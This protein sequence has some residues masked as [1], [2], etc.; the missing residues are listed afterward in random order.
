MTPITVNSEPSAF[1]R[2][3]L[4]PMTKVLNPL[5]RRLAGRKHF[6]Q[7]ARLTHLGRRSGRA[8]VTPVSARPGGGHFWVALT[9]GTGSDWCRNVVAAGGC[10][11]R[12]HGRD[13][14]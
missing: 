11:L 8:Y 12:W 6:N 7:A 14:E 9:F 1:A 5:I 4:R 13:Y 2:V 10:S 3:A